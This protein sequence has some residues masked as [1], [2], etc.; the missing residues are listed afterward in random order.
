MSTTESVAKKGGGFLLERPAPEE[1]FTPED[2]NEE[3][4]M[5]AKTTEDFVKEKV[6]PVLEEIENHNFDHTVRLLKQAGEL[7]LLGADVPEEY[8]GF[9]LAKSPPP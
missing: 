3:Q 6:W 8:G 5:I 4:K 2:I 7:G 1:I 9:G